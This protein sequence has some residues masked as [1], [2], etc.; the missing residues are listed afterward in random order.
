VGVALLVAAATMHLSCASCARRGLE[1]PKVA[2]TVFPLYDLTRR[3][4][5]DRLDV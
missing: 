2:V 4:A 1:R 3:L 5:G